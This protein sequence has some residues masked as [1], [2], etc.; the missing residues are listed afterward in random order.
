METF[1]TAAPKKEN[2]VSRVAQ[3][4]NFCGKV[5][6]SKGALPQD[7]VDSRSVAGPTQLAIVD[8]V[9]QGQDCGLEMRDCEFNSCVCI[10]YSMIYFSFVTLTLVLKGTLSGTCR[11]FTIR[12]SVNLPLES[13]LGNPN[14]LS[15][16]QGNLGYD[17]SL[18]LF[19]SSLQH[20]SIPGASQKCRTSG[21]L[22]LGACIYVLRSL[23]DSQHI[24]LMS[25]GKAQAFSIFLF[26]VLL[27][28]VS[29]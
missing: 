22:D 3:P 1:I 16:S 29:I 18:K 2:S 11:I 28:P 10:L 17:L 20:I 9:A 12:P 7:R 25:S 4:G 27:S 23:G 8:I 21:P 26:V 6:P 5:Q 19:Y 15:W 24:M 14:R 13:C